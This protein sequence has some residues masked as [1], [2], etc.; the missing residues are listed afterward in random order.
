MTSWPYA[1]GLA[2]LAAVAVIGGLMFGKRTA[3]L[4]VIVFIF[5][6]LLSGAGRIAEL[7]G[8]QSSE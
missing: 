1:K 4:L 6:I 7:V 5:L 3:Y 2:V 8:G